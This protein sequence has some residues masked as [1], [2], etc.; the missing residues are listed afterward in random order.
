VSSRNRTDAA[1]PTSAAHHRARS[2]GLAK[3]AGYNWRTPV[4]ADISRYKPGG[5]LRGSFG[6]DRCLIVIVFVVARASRGSVKRDSTSVVLRG[7]RPRAD[8]LD[9]FLNEGGTPI[10]ARLVSAKED[11]EMSTRLPHPAR[12]GRCAMI[13]R[14]LAFIHFLCVLRPSWKSVPSLLPWQEVY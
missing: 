13:S 4:E 9:R 3:A 14:S 11:P 7:I 5:G 1:R 12:H 6:Y 8:P 10:D 2:H